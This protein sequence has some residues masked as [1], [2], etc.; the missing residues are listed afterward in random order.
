MNNSILVGIG[1]LLLGGV[2]GYVAGTSGAGTADEEKPEV[3]STVPSKGIRTGTGGSSSLGRSS[4][5]AGS[6]EAIMDTPGQTARLQSLMDFY[7][8]LDPAQFADE[9]AK[10]EDLPFGE[11][12]IAGYLLFS[13]WAEVD[14]AGALAHTREM[15]RSGFMVRGTVLQSWAASDPAGAARYYEENPGEFGMMGGFGGRGSSASG[16]IAAEWAKQDPDGALAWAQGLEGRDA[17][18]AI[19]SI[20]RQVAQDDPAKAAAMAAGLGDDERS[21]AYR[22][23]AREWAQ[24]DWSDAEAWISSLPV[25]ER[26]AVM[27]QAIRGLASNDPVEASQKIANLPDGEDKSD[28]I[29]SIAERWARDDAGAAAE[30]LVEAGGED[31]GRSMREVMGNW[32]GQDSAAALEFVNSQPEG[33]LRDS[34]ASSYVFSNRNGDLQESLKVAESIS[35]EDARARTVGMTAMRWMQE[36]KE[37]ATEYIETTTALSDEAKTRIIERAENGFG[38]GGFDRGRGGPGGRR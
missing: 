21:G 8:G 15:G 25:D 38:R 20:F 31:A 13:R 10:L 32:V 23:I 14:P 18:S 17:S 1:A 12:M 27:A 16:Q 6:F 5:K 30:W 34:A 7:A 35:N 9:A 3:A 37:A 22:S 2:G 33:E 36:D 24:Q 28:A 4:S 11:R 26:D 29:R 19:G